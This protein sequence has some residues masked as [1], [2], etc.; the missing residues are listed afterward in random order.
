MPSTARLLYYDLG[1]SADDDGFVSPKRVM[2]MTGASD[3]DLKLLIA[4]RYV[5]PFK[6]GVIV[7]KHWKENNYIQKDRYK[8]TLCTEEKKLLCLEANVYK[9]DTECIQ[10]V[11]IG[12]VREGKGRE[13]KVIFKE[14]KEK[15]NLS[16]EG[17]AIINKFNEVF[18]NCK[19]KTDKSFRKNMFYW[20]ESYSIDDILKAIELAKNH[21]FWSDKLDPVKLFRTRNKAGD[22]DNIGS[23]LGSERKEKT[24]R[25]IMDE[26]AKSIGSKIIWE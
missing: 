5:I 21:E 22:C 1:M 13:G 18:G 20:L 4:K 17:L 6:S 25:E 15:E 16:Q 14:K 7:I 24:Q 19:M 9:M 26:E 8:E 2:R 3:D 12:K 11:R 23:L 10:N